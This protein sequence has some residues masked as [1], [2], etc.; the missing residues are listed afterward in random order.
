[1]IQTR[2][3]PLE[4]S[5]PLAETP[6]H[7]LTETFFQTKEWVQLWVTHFDKENK[8]FTLGVFDQE[9]MI[10]AGS[11]TTGKTGISLLGVTP[12]LGKEIVSDY[13]DIFAKNSLE[14]VVWKEILAYMKANH[15]DSK[16]IR[17]YFIRED[18]PSFQILKDYTSNIEQAD[19]AAYID[20]P[21]SWDEYLSFLDRHN[22]HELRRKIRK[23]EK[24]NAFKV[25]FEGNP[26]DIDEFFRLMSLSNEQKRDFLSEDMKKFF[27]DIFSIFWR[28]NMLRLCFMKLGG[29]NI[30]AVLCFIYNK[31]LLL[32]NSGYD[33]SF[34]SLSPGFILKSY[35][36]K[37]AIEQGLEKFDFLRGSER[38]K[39]DLGAKQRVLYNITI[40]L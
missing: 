9:K 11:F 16:D 27:W 23:L 7:T 10:G 32:Y 22:R 30:A 38:Y 34:N 8:N 33:P 35:M 3:I 29:K 25:C 21:Y 31:Q 4:T 19:I 26:G 28:K 17:L 14:E 13:G 15:S 12:V 2:I 20:L 1:M 24:E 6:H 39:F 5:L 36:I 40:P 18:S 37:Y